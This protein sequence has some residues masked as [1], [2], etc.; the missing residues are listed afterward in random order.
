[1]KSPVSPFAQL[2]AEQ[3]ARADSAAWRQPHSELATNWPYNEMGFAR[4]CRAAQL[5]AVRRRQ[6]AH[7]KG[8]RNVTEHIQVNSIRDRDLR[9]V[10]AHF[11][12]HTA[13]DEARLEC[14]SCSRVITWDNLG[15]LRVSGATLV[16]Y[17][18]FSECLESASQPRE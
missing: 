9:P 2:A 12:L 17:C 14:A 10:L 11:H 16:V 15:A 7:G 3:L 4:I 6:L 13:V 5:G 8:R 18:D 1:M